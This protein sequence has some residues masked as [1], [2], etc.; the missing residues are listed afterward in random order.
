MK[1]AELIH[2]TE[3]ERCLVLETHA[4]CLIQRM[5]VC[6]FPSAGRGEFQ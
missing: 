1:Y 5:G 6:L 2:Y 3:T 4:S